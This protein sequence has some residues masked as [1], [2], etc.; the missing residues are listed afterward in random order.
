MRACS[1][2]EGRRRSR[3]KAPTLN[4]LV[5]LLRTGCSQH[6]PVLVSG[7]GRALDRPDDRGTDRRRRSLRD[8]RCS[9]SSPAGPKTKPTWGNPAHLTRLTLNRLGQRQCACADRRGHRGKALPP[10]GAGRD[11]PQG[12]RRAAVRRRADEDRAAVGSARTSAAGY[13]L[14]GRYP[15]GDTVDIAGLIDGTTGPADRAKEVSQVGAAIGREFTRSLLAQVLQAPRGSAG[16]VAGRTGRGGPADSAGR[17]PS[18][19][20][21]FKHA[22]VRDTAYNSMLKTTRAL[23]HKQIAEALEQLDPGTIAGLPELRATDD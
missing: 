23:R 10:R 13:R 12:R 9:S 15:T 11:H 20:Y 7:R 16:Q 17:R 8:A 18:A 5:D 3:Q 4:A 21:A 6:N 14:T 2:R 19:S 22:L 1:A